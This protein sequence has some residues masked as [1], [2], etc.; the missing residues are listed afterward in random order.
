MD[1][2][3]VSK[4]LRVEYSGL[5]TLV[6]VLDSL[7]W[8]EELREYPVRIDPQIPLLFLLATDDSYY[9]FNFDNEALYYAG[10]SVRDVIRGL[11]MGAYLGS[12]YGD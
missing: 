11:R 2:D 12:D 7:T 5:K 9:I 10:K 1:D 8:Q 6:P 3:W 4:Y